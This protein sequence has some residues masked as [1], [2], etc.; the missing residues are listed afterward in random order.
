[1]GHVVCVNAKSNS[2]EILKRL[3]IRATRRRL[4]GAVENDCS[5]KAASGRKKSNVPEFLR[6]VYARPGWGW[7]RDV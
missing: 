2:G 5:P 4:T 3:R 1:M 7:R 6:E